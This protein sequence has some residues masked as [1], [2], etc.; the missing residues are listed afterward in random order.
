MPCRPMSVSL[1]V[2]P[3]P[4]QKIV[5]GLDKTC[6]ADD[7]ATWTLNFE[8][9]EGRPLA[10]VIKLDVEIDPENHPQAEATAA[11]GLDENQRAA[12][13]VAASVAKDKTATEDDKKQAAQDVIAARAMGVG[14]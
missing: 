1:E 8:L 10:T 6:D 3:R 14:V 5:F 13:R 9:Q 11:K 7:E 4:T 2:D 12:A